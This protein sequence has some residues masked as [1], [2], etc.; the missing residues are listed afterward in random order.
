M[1]KICTIFL[2]ISILLSLSGCGTEP[3]NGNDTISESAATASVVDK[4]L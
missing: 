1:K 2:S 3:K 4:Q